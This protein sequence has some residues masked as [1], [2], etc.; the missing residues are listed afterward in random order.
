MRA[1]PR[2]RS[3]A[4]ELLLIDFGA[5]LNGYCS[6]LT[7]TVVVGRADDRQR[8]IYELVQEAQAAGAD[9]GAGPA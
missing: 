9:P 1:P 2:G 5:Q 8:T 3:S 6:D 4:N 7:R